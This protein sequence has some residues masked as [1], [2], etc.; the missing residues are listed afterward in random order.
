MEQL[1][2]VGVV[3]QGEAAPDAVVLDLANLPRVLFFLFRS[4]N[5]VSDRMYRKQRKKKEI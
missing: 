2:I 1:A 4:K 3:L 5:T